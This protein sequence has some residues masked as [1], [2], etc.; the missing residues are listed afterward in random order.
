MTVTFQV[1]DREFGGAGNLEIDFWVG[2]P[3]Y[4]LGKAETALSRQRWAR[5]FQNSVDSPHLFT[6]RQPWLQPAALFKQQLLTRLFVL[7]RSSA[8]PMNTW[9]TRKVSPLAT[10]PSMLETMASTYTASATKLG[11]RARRRSAS[12]C[13]GLCMCLRARRLVIRWNL[14]VRL[15][16]LCSLFTCVFTK[17]EPRSVGTSMAKAKVQPLLEE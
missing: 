14:K 10:I 6:Y 4:T 7:S 3:F 12:M 1:G 2:V 5:T 16:C 17:Y 11:L 13:M 8:Q 9:S 15:T